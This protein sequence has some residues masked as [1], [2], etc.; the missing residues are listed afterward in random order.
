M[1]IMTLPVRSPDGLGAADRHRVD[2]DE[3]EHED[4][5]LGD[6]KKTVR[7]HCLDIPR[8]EESPDD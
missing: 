8:F 7:G 6:S 2:D 5:D 4:P 3:E 1:C